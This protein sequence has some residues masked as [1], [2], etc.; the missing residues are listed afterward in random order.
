MRWA[1]AI[2]GAPDFYLVH[3]EPEAQQVLQQGLVEA[4]IQA[5]IPQQGQQILF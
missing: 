1:T 3:G 4:G 5:Q 2:G